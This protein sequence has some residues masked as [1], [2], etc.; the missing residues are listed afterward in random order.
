[1]GLKHN[2][3]QLATVSDAAVTHLRRGN[4]KLLDNPKYDV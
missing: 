3:Q 2:L 4:K 1:M